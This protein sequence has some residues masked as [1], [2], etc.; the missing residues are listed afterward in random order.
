[1]HAENMSLVPEGI[2]KIDASGITS[3]SGVREEFYAIVL[4]TGFEVAN[5]LGPLKVVGRNS[6]DLHEQWNSGLGAQA[7]MG[8]YVHNFPNFA[9]M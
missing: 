1:M 5:F 4:A 6:I 7:Y 9:L 2:S 8:V 3:A